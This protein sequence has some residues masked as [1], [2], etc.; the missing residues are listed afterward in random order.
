[1][2]AP[3]LETYAL[4]RRYGQLT[5]VDS[6][7]LSVDEGEIFGLLGPNGVGKTTT[8]KMLTTLLPP[9]SGDARIAGRDVVHQAGEVRRLIGYV[10]QLLSADGT[11]TAY[12]NLDVF[13]K[14]YDIPRRE[15]EDRIAEGRTSWDWQI[16]PTSWSATI[17][18]G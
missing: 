15:R 17:P 11:L 2:S 10:P 9:T 6:L 18:A 3:I 5:A 13:A 12:E 1:M 16:P 7:T 4:T 8:L 14:L